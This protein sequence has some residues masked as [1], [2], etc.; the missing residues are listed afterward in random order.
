MWMMNGLP[1]TIRMLLL[2]MDNNK[3]FSLNKRRKFKERELKGYSYLSYMKGIING[4]KE[5]KILHF[6]L[7]RIIK[8]D[9]KNGDETNR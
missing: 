1:R 2:R 8:V 4:Y 5:N 6:P 9:K 3:I 7:N